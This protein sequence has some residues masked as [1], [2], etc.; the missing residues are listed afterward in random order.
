VNL[1]RIIKNLV[2]KSLVRVKGRRD[3]PGRPMVYGTTDHFLE[4]FGLRAIDDL[5]I[6]KEFQEADLEYEKRKQ[7][8]ILALD[9]TKGD[10]SS[11]TEEIATEN[12]SDGQRDS[13][14][15]E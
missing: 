14:I 1:D 2:D 10:D 11:G 15:A 13:S 5:P 3:A 6:L 7:D 8:T 9:D 4:R 12:K